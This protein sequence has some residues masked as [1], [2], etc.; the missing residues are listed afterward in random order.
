[1]GR[2]VLELL[3]AMTLWTSVAPVREQ[4]ELLRWEAPGSCPSHA[5]LVAA[6]AVN[7][8]RPLA[9]RDAEALTVHAAA[10]RRS[11]GRWELALT[12]E[13]RDAAAVARTVIADQCPLL[14]EAAA[15]IVA[16]AIDPDLL[17]GTQEPRAAPTSREPN[18]VPL[19]VSA[20]PA[21][22]TPA[23]IE[24]AP[25]PPLTQ[26]RRRSIQAAITAAA[27]L[28]AGA[29]P[30]PAP[31]LRVGIGLL[32]RRMRVEI[33]AL[34]LFARP[35]PIAGQDGNKIGSAEIRLTAAQ[36]QA[37]PR[38]ARGRLELPVCAGLELG[39]MRGQGIGLAGATTDRVVWLAVLADARALGVPIPRL[40]LGL[41]LGLAVPLLAARFR[42]RVLDADL[43][44]AA[45]VGFRGALTV[46][47][48]FP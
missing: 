15:L 20:P 38:F 28:D 31:G 45:P 27:T 4:G 3:A 12:I 6:I 21:I 1:M 16:V 34:H 42:V 30:G 17:A 11:D 29:L 40:A 48:R 33:G 23:A 5:R 14:A 32:T 18:G 26:P 13:P 35:A 44:K 46:E 22:T 19:E 7:L 37:C 2:T 25:A 24:A 39:T 9:A 10:R 41:Q 8:G 43:H 47:L 36:L